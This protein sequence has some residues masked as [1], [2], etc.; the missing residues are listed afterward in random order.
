MGDVAGGAGR[1]P[2]R[3][4][5]YREDLAISERLAKSDPNNTGWLSNLAESYAM[6]AGVYRRSD[7][8]DGALAALRKGQAIMARRAKLS[9]GEADWRRQLAWFGNQIAALTK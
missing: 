5:S 1:P 6:P 4:R 9:P 2:R 7:D 8:A 3:A